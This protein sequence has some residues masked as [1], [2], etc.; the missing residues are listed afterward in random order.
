[1]F[2][3]AGV[4]DLWSNYLRKALTI[5]SDRKENC[6]DS[7]SKPGSFTRGLSVDKDKLFL[8]FIANENLFVLEI[9]FLEGNLMILTSEKRLDVSDSQKGIVQFKE[10]EN[11]AITRIV[12][13]PNDRWICMEMANGLQLWIKGF[14]KMGNVLLRDSTNNSVKQIFRLSQKS[15]WGFVFPSLDPSEW[16][17]RSLISLENEPNVSESVPMCPIKEVNTFVPG[18][19]LNQRNKQFSIEAL[20]H[21]QRGFIR[22]YYFNR[23]KDQMIA[24]LEKK[25]KLLSK[26]LS[27]TN[28]R[29]QEIESRRS[30]KEL[31]DILLTHAHSLKP[32]LSKAL[33]TDYFTQQR[34]WI[35]L[36][37]TL[38]A[39]ENA[40]KYYGKAKNERIESQKIQDKHQKTLAQITDFQHQLEKVK[41]ASDLKA[42]KTVQKI[43]KPLGLKSQEPL[44]YKLYECMGYQIWL[45][46]NNKSNDQMLKLSQKNDLW[47]H[48]KDVS[49]SHV[50]IKKKGAE[51]PKAVVDFA[52][53]LAAKNSKAKN[54]GI[55]PVIAVLRKYVSK[56][57]Q[58]ALGEVRLQKEDCIDAFL[59]SAN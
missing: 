57:K 21:E 17:T 54:Q 33:V 3:T 42:I 24:V 30:N 47:L 15:D 18:T 53:Q 25:I 20:C 40:N 19:V 26:I 35:K 14:G 10:I 43:V 41:N 29:K 45:G 23:N 34:I 7:I 55:V 2:S 31:G 9:Q 32:G 16:H 36:N 59:D 56:P 37:A 49:G 5:T 12:N 28:H 11:Q 38:S 22:Q 4:F 6:V 8:K 51:Y 52:A 46:K 39:V 27:E 44:P 1:M 50:I 58:A 48:A 13:D